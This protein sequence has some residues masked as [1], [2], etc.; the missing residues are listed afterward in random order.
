MPQT[1]LLYDVPAISSGFRMSSPAKPRVEDS[2]KN[3]FQQ[4]LDQFVFKLQEF[5]YEE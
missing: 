4:L 2:E 1:G 5:Y 3:T